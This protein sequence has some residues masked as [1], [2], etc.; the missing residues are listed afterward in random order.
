MIE[1]SIFY[2]FFFVD[3]LYNPLNSLVYFEVVILV[4]K[5]TKI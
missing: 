3:F 1:S 4:Y 5:S 2:I